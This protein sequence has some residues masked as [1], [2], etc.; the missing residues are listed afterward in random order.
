[1]QNIRELLYPEILAGLKKREHSEHKY[2]MHRLGNIEEISALG[3]F[4]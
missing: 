4:V 3:W 2:V 1:M